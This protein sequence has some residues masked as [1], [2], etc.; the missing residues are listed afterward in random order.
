MDAAKTWSKTAIQ[1]REPLRQQLERLVRRPS[2]RKIS[3]LAFLDPYFFVESDR[4]ALL[5]SA[6]DA[7]LG[8]TGADMGNVQLCDPI[9]HTLHIEAQRGF[10]SPFL[11]FFARVHDGQ[12][13]CGLAMTRAER[14]T[15]ADVV[16]SPIFAGTPALDVMVEAGARAVQSTPLIG[17]SGRLLGM[18]STHYHRT[19]TPD[20][21]RPAPAG[22]S[23]APDS[24]L[25]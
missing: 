13:A 23:R 6:L 24:A 17:S 19:A 7:A 22:S 2:R 14:V 12:A 20:R 1:M 9:S 3:G 5:V 11:D 10:E 21:D 4:H 15:V 8:L 25:D 18:F 16:S